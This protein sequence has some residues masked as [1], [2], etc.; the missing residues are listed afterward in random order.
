MHFI[1]GAFTFLP[2]Y[3]ENEHISF[4]TYLCCNASKL[5]HVINGVS[6]IH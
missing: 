4:V 5:R 2:I 3:V 6:Q 1:D